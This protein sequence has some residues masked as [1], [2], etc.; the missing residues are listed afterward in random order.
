MMNGKSDSKDGD[1][2]FRNRSTLKCR[3]DAC[4][5]Y[6]PPTPDNPPVAERPLNPPIVAV[7]TVPCAK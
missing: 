6:T 2:G 4:T 1:G 3:A 5:L 7:D